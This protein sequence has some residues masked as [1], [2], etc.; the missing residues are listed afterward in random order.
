MALPTPNIDGFSL[1]VTIYIDADNVPKFFEA[2]NTVFDKVSQEPELLY[3]E[4]FQDPENPGTISWVENWAKSPEKF[5]NV[6]LY[7]VVEIEDVHRSIAN[8]RIGEFAKRVLQAVLRS[9]RT[10]VCET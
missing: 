8:L 5:F 9:D 6:H 10:D 7:V 3:F 2:M 4:I 1:H